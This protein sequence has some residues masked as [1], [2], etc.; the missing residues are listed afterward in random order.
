MGIQKVAFNFMVERGGKLAKSLLCSKPQKITE[1]KNLKYIRTEI[2]TFKTSNPLLDFYKNH[3]QELKTLVTDEKGNF[4]YKNA[5]QTKLVEISRKEAEQIGSYTIKGGKFYKTV[6]IQKGKTIKI[7]LDKEYKKF[8]DDLGILEHG[9]SEDAY[10]LILKNGFQVNNEKFAETFH[11]IYF[12]RQLDGINNYG[13]RKILA[14]INGDIAYGDA[15]KISD[16]LHSNNPKLDKY[17]K[18]HGLIDVPVSDIKEM[19]LK[20]E[21]VLRGYRGFYASEDAFFAQCKPVVIFNPKD[22]EIIK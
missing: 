19:L 6:V 9:T 14:K 5:D 1:F 18:E 16:F 2:D 21:F 8:T 22:I 13:E 12:T 15:D 3:K 7:N 11:G 4:I 10:H 20:D 17:L